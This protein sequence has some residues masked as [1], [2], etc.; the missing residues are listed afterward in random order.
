MAGQIFWVA[1]PVPAEALAVPVGWQLTVLN[2][3]QAL[4]QTAVAQV[5]I[6]DQ[7]QQTAVTEL[8]DLFQQSIRVLAVP[9]CQDELLLPFLNHYHLFCPQPLRAETLDSFIAI[10]TA[11]Q[12]LPL[13]SQSRSQLLA[14]THLPLLPPLVLEL[15]ELLLDPDVKITVLAEL[16]EQDVVLS[17][18]LLQ[19]ANS[20]YMGFNHETASLQMAIS[21]LGLSLLYGL[22]L[23]L[24]VAAAQS[25]ATSLAGIRLVNHCRQV[26]QWL[27]LDNS[28]LEQ[29]V[30]TALFYQL[31]ESLLQTA[32][33]DVSAVD[34]AQAGAFVLTL[35]GFSSDVAQLLLCQ[36]TLQQCREHPLALCLYLARQRQPLAQP[37]AELAAVLE[38]KGLRQHWPATAVAKA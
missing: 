7:Q 19:L 34:A 30:L 5:L 14:C 13:A 11:L 31:G 33:G 16:I 18:R 1:E 36:Q 20:A 27:G 22:V 4:Q 32:Q 24:S 8:A 25:S 12:N 10:A 9:D 6:V 3:E 23:A 35:W 2:T 17:A 29:V 26:G 15:Q 38:Q 21:R 37:D 28:A